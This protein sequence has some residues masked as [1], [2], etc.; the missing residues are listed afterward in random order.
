MGT[1]EIGSR[2]NLVDPEKLAAWDRILDALQAAGHRF[3]TGRETLRRHKPAGTLELVDGRDY[4]K[5][6][7][8]RLVDAC[9]W[10]G[11]AG[12]ALSG[13]KDPHRMSDQESYSH[14]FTAARAW[15][16]LRDLSTPEDQLLPRTKDVLISFCSAHRSGGEELTIKQ[17][18]LDRANRVVKAFNVRFP[19]AFGADT[20]LL[21]KALPSGWW[22]V[23]FRHPRAPAGY[24]IFSR[25]RLLSKAWTEE[26]PCRIASLARTHQLWLKGPLPAGRHTLVAFPA[27]QRARGLRVRQDETGLTIRTPRGHIRF[28]ALNGGHLAEWCVDGFSPFAAFGRIE[29]ATAWQDAPLCDE[30]L[31]AFSWE[32]GAWGVRVECRYPVG[33]VPV[34]RAW[35]VTG[36]LL[37]C[38]ARVRFGHR[39]FQFLSPGAYRLDPKTFGKSARCVMVAEGDTRLASEPLRVFHNVH[40]LGSEGIGFL[41]EKG[42]AGL[43][44]NRLVSSP[45]LRRNPLSG[46]FLLMDSRPVGAADEAHPYEFAEEPVFEATLRLAPG[47]TQKRT[48]AAWQSFH[49]H[50]PLVGAGNSPFVEATPEWAGGIPH[51]SEVNPHF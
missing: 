43:A 45:I 49:D 18:L 30:T 23:P 44:V 6:D 31:T 50:P 14:A 46:T 34:H 16:H 48:F 47:A 24:A 1:F 13:R 5:N 20:L 40:H 17:Q 15:Q 32:I 39:R 2:K 42:L 10:H 29:L 19:A 35:V 26:A 25:N 12:A 37:C 38:Q 33:E 21:R 7:L 4:T 8:T 28:D 51:I 36:D 22:P 41:G 27:I 3:I 9:G 11:S